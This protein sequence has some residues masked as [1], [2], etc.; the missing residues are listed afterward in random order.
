MSPPQPKLPLRSRLW[1]AVSSRLGQVGSEAWGVTL[2]LFSV[3]LT[4]FLVG[5]GGP[6]GE[7]VKITFTYLFGQWSALTPLALLGM[8]LVLVL[9]KPALSKR[10]LFFAVMVFFL[11]TLGLFH[12]LTGAPSL[13]SGA[14]VIR[15]RGGAVGALVAFPLDRTIGYASTFVILVGGVTMSV[16]MVSR[17]P[18]REF[19][20]AVGELMMWAPRVIRRRRA[21]SRITRAV[22]ASAPNPPSTPARAPNRAAGRRRGWRRKALGS[23]PWPIAPVLEVPDADDDPTDLEAEVLAAL[24]D[25]PETETADSGP[26][27]LQVVEDPAPV[28]P[29]L[30]GQNGR[31]SEAGDAPAGPGTP[32]STAP[33]GGAAPSAEYRLPPL[34]LLRKG[35]KAA[36]N[37]EGLKATAAALRKALSDHGVD[38][39]ITGVVSGPSVTRFEIELAAGVKVQKLSALS[40]DI[41]YALATPDV[42]LLVPIPGRSAIGVEVPNVQ[43]R[44]VRL[45]DI[46]SSP[47]AQAEQRPLVVGLGMDIS[48]KPCFLDLAELPHVLIA[49]ATGAGKSSCINS[50]ITSLLTRTRPEDLNLILVDPKRVEL[51]QYEGVPHLLTRVITDPKKAAEGL[52]WVVAEMDRRYDLLAEAEVRDISGYAAKWRM[53]G[54]APEKFDLFPYLVVVVDELNDLMMVA[55]REVEMAIV[56]IAQMARAV[57]IHLVLATQRPSV[58]VITG[59]IKANVPS[60]LA[61]SV[62]S[63]TDSR[64]IIDSVGAEKLV[65][66]GDMLVVTARQPRPQRIQGAWVDEAEIAR[67][68]SW[69]TRQGRPDGS[70]DEVLEMAI[71]EKAAGMPQEDDEDEEL[72]RQ[73]M[74]LVVR[75]QLGSTSMLQRKLRVGFARAGRLMDILERRGVVGPSLGSKAREVL[76]GPDEL[77]VR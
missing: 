45:G 43:R 13:A 2:V 24:E 66:Q 14:E 46:L 31:V 55:G 51:R 8:G 15:E 16:L 47:E 59:V 76:I 54:L 27:R 52:K 29:D 42:R 63:Q 60:R 56:R 20:V 58:N 1:S 57:G 34:D 69:V 62:A 23:G 50:M 70:V 37:S 5:A 7:A 9:G 73:A 25:E 74:E 22:A 48:G 12:L 3:I 40:N 49:G 75:S 61:F 18:L 11:S 64:V 38:A 4:L 41:A 44:I 30:S 68:V 36:G 10:R 21:L 32:E 17:T 28:G 65:G 53:G 26:A 72:L 35:E 71:S 19:F 67:V 6:A 39:R 77:G 33:D